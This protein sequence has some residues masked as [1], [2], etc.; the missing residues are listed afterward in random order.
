M[1][2][3]CRADDV[4]WSAVVETAGWHDSVSVAVCLCD[5]AAASLLT[6]FMAVRKD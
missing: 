4:L 1:G 6:A 2:L 3:F 5:A